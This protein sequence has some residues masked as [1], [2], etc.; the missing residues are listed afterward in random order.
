MPP[1]ELRIVYQDPQGG[2]SP[3]RARITHPSSFAD[4][5]RADITVL[6]VG[7]DEFRC[8]EY[9]LI[10]TLLGFSFVTRRA[11]ILFFVKVGH[12]LQSVLWIEFP[13]FKTLGGSRLN[14]YA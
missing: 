5:Q 11:T 9:V 3:M 8:S 13:R 6:P 2:Y 1:P 7:M 12:A 10:M 14:T 4:R